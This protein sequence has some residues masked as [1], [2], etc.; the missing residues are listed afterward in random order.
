MASSHRKLFLIKGEPKPEQPSIEQDG[1]KLDYAGHHHYVTKFPPHPPPSCLPSPSPPLPHSPSPDHKHSPPDP[2]PCLPTPSP[3]LSHS[4]SSNHKHLQS[5]LISLSF[6]FSLLLLVALFLWRRYV[7]NS[8]E[9]DENWPTS[10]DEGFSADNGR[11]HHAWIINTMGLQQSAI[12]LIAVCKYKTGDG[13]IEGTDCSVCLNEFQEDESLRLLPKCSHAFHLSCIDPWL[14]FHKNCP[15]CRAPVI[16]DGIDRDPEPNSNDSASVEETQMDNLENNTRSDEIEVDINVSSDEN[17]GGG[18]GQ[19]VRNSISMD[20]GS[21]QENEE[22]SGE[23]SQVVDIEAKESDL[24]S[25]VV[26]KKKKKK[27]SSGNSRLLCCNLMKSSSLGRRSLQ[28]GPVSMKRS[29]SSGRL[30]FVSRQNKRHCHTP[31]LTT[32]G[33]NPDLLFLGK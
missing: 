32:S 20:S 18:G 27:Q 22:G 9:D 19:Q 17:G 31:K 2:P 12:D 30:L 16:A 7:R 4:S 11:H 3:P 28:M 15:L 23:E 14:R 26:E 21:G 25:E 1:C 33:V 10:D 6:L 29:F 5:Y 24:N 8:R 13:L